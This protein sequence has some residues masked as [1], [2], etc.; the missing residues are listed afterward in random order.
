MASPDG[1]N[2]VRMY[3]VFTVKSYSQRGNSVSRYG[4]STNYLEKYDGLT[5]QLISTKPYQCD[6]NCQIMKVTNGYLWLR[7]YD[8][9]T[10]KPHFFVLRL[11]DF[12]KMYDDEALAQKNN[13]IVFEPATMYYNPPNVSG[14]LIK[15]DDNRIYS[16]DEASGK[17]TSMPDSLSL[18]IM[19]RPFLQ[20]GAHTFPNAYFSFST[21]QRPRLN[22]QPKDSKLVAGKLSSASDFISPYL[23]AYYN[24]ALKSE[25]AIMAN[26][27]CIVVSKT[28]SSEDFVFQFTQVDTATLQTNWSAALNYGNNKISENDLLDIQLHGEHLLVIEKNAMGF[29]DINS[30]KWKWNKV[31]E[32]DKK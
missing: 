2:I 14:V 5:G 25:E 12:T 16:L 22:K 4:F 17:A 13:G 28:K 6:G 7:T 3:Q 27:G 8:T 11:S 24:P 29:L 20:S 10:S 21:G 32:K 26:K 23:A 9:K 31:F 15:G 19:G 18:R 1:K 30:G